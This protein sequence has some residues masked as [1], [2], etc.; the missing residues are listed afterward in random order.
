MP[1]IAKALAVELKGKSI[2]TRQTGFILLREL[3]DCL[4]GG[5]ENSISLFIKPIESSLSASTSATSGRAGTNSNLKIET[6]LFLRSLFRNHAPEIFRPHLSKL[7]PPVLAAAGDKFY[8]IVSEALLVFIELIKVLRPISS[9]GQDFTVHPVADKSHSKYLDDIYAVTM[10][11]LETSDVDWEVK[12]RAITCLGIFLSQAG[13]LLPKDQVKKVALPLLVD[14]LK[15]EL[16]RLTAVKI[17]KFITES[18]LVNAKSNAIDLT[19]VLKELVSEIASYLRK[20]H[21]LLR[22]AS[23]STLES[24]I[25]VYGKNIEPETYPAILNEVKLLLIDSDF[26]IIPMA[27]STMV[28]IVHIGSTSNPTIMEDVRKEVIPMLVKL[29]REQP[30]LLSNGQALENLLKTWRCFVRAGGSVVFK[31]SIALLTHDIESGDKLV[32]FLLRL[33]AY[34]LTICTR[35][36]LSL[37][38]L[39]RRLL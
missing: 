29:I 35:R 9:D 7:V 26:N 20:S 36:I 1:K 34:I 32:S 16:T 8:K 15:N 14:R 5:L 33:A 6:L 37:R 23:L 39:Y 38:N 2:A 25:V 3:V 17:I 18:P 4:H 13:D 30:Y 19:P 24:L 27:M 31:E 11:K 21:R 12:E 28:Q 22:Q 10:S